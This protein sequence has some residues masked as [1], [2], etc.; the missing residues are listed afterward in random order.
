M[1]FQILSKLNLEIR[2]N[3]IFIVFQHILNMHST[4]GEV[5]CEQCG[6]TVK[7]KWYLRRHKV[8]HHGAP[9]RKYKKE[10]DFGNG[11]DGHNMDQSDNEDGAGD[12][13]SQLVIQP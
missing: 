6:K 5:R 4:G 10:Q 7:N 13:G 11:G 1:L 12:Q 8:T 9:L 3:R 2:F